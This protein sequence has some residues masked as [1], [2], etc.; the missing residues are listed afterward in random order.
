MLKISPIQPDVMES[1][2]GG[3]LLMVF[4]LPFLAGGI[5]VWCIAF[6]ILP[7]E[8]D[9]IPLFFG[10]PFGAVFAAVG[11]GLMFGRAGT[12]VDRRHGQVTR[13]WGLLGP[14]KKRQYRLDEFQR[15]S[16]SREVRRS[17]KSTYT[18][19]PVRLSGAATVKLAEPRDYEK[20]RQLAE[21]LAKFVSLPLADTSSGTEVVRDAEHLDEAL[22]DRLRRTGESL[23]LPPAPPDMRT[24]LRQKG[25]AVMMELPAIGLNPAIAVMIGAGLVIPL[26]VLGVFVLPLLR[27]DMP[28][29]MR[30]FFLG[31]IGLFFVL[32]PLVAL[33]GQA[34]RRAKARHR[35]IVTPEELRYEVKGLFRVVS[36]CIPA[37]EL[38]EI[39]AEQTTVDTAQVPE[40]LASLTRGPITARSDRLTLQFAAHLP[41]EEK[42]Y[43]VAVITRV[44]AGP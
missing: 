20:A 34:L 11:A 22:A 5:M 24:R 3:G 12:V 21:E 9:Q 14:W 40:L 33:V 26:F 1:R 15:V 10:L 32:I 30:W 19:Y 39:T 37:A 43:L 13:W 31:F 35:V 44:L 23:E 41:L 42:E 38:E 17:N 16:I 18:V 25:D 28:A 6:G 7:T 29:P 2:T 36:R 8:G 4:G 27:E